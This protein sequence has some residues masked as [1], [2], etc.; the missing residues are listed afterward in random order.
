MFALY[1]NRGGASA[2]YGFAFCNAMSMLSPAQA[3][4]PALPGSGA[5]PALVGEETNRGES[6]GRGH[7]RKRPPLVFPGG[8]PAA[9]RFAGTIFLNA[10]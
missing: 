4:D 5:D 6:G 9:K 8:R 7:L 10:N 1:G 3:N 2:T